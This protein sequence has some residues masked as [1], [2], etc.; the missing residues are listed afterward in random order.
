M[1]SKKL[2]CLVTTSV[3]LMG[4]VEALQPWGRRKASVGV[5]RKLN[6]QD[7]KMLMQAEWDRQDKIRKAKQIL[8]DDKQPPDALTRFGRWFEE[9]MIG[10]ERFFEDFE[11]NRQHDEAEFE[12][13][14]RELARAEATA[15]YEVDPPPYGFGIGNLIQKGEGCFGR[16]YV[17]P[18]TVWKHDNEGSQPVLTRHVRFSMLYEWAWRQGEKS[19]AWTSFP[20]WFSGRWFGGKHDLRKQSLGQWLAGLEEPEDLYEFLKDEVQL[21]TFDFTYESP[22]GKVQVK[23]PHNK[24]TVKM[25]GD[26]KTREFKNDIVQDASGESHAVYLFNLSMDIA[27]TN[28][29]AHGNARGTQHVNAPFTVGLQYSEFEK[30]YSLF[31]KKTLKKEMPSKFEDIKAI[32]KSSTDPDLIEERYP[33]FEDLLGDMLENRHLLDSEQY[34]DF[35]SMLVRHTN[36]H[37]NERREFTQNLRAECLDAA[38]DKDVTYYKFGLSDEIIVWLRNKDFDEFKKIFARQTPAI[39]TVSRDVKWFGREDGTDPG[40]IE[41]R[42]ALYPKVL[43]SMFDEL[44]KLDT[45]DFDIFYDLLMEHAEKKK[46]FQSVRDLHQF[47]IG[48]SE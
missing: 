43:N 22:H 30:L 32:F 21:S 42:K 11:M 18:V 48:Q 1:Q 14:V 25:V 6:R 31:P 13:A 47:C 34:K 37:K 12:A 38:V 15:R 17:Y 10:V 9:R 26:E 4:G 40:V 46:L 5:P 44:H 28:V 23:N 33:K 35:M 29:K 2:M 45:K 36:E 3:A 20:G 41:K 24:V 8:D 16:Y 7:D 19:K 27:K 39:E